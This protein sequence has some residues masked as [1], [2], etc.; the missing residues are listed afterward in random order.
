MAQKETIGFI[1]LGIMGKPMALNLIKA[2]Y[3][4]TVNNRTPEVMEEL[5]QA[6]ARAAHSA[7]EVAGQSDIIITMLPDS[8]QV[9]EVALGEGGVIEGIRPGALFIDMSSV[10]PNTSRKVQQALSARGADALDAPV[11]GGQVGAEGATLSIM[12]GGSEESFNRARPVFEAMGKNIVHIGGPG[13]GQVTKIANQI[14]VGLTIQAVSEAM[15]LAKKSGVDA[16]K[17][18]EALLGGFAQSR[19]LDL[20]GQRM[21]DGNFK[22]GFRIGLHRKDLRLALETGR[23]AGVPLFA[24]GIAANIMDAMI[25]QGD[26]DLDHSG[27]AKFYAQMSGIE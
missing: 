10:S 25:A 6:G 19:I 18:R 7:R 23:E 14:V 26:G 15:T 16:G 3:A 1:G 12:V 8:P 11:S 2:G 5:V 24:T 17:V 22:P 27:M 13:A 21:L 20:H 4:L 9:E